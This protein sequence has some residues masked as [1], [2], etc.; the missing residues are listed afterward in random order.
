[1]K[2]PF[3]ILSIPI[4]PYT[5]SEILSC[6]DK[7]IEDN[8]KTFIVTANAEIVMKANEIS[9]FKELICRA[10]I[11]LPD[12]AGVVWAGKYLGYDVPERVA[13][14]DLVQNIFPLATKKNYK[15]Y[16]LGS[17][18]G[19]AATAAKNILKKHP[20]LDIVGTHDGFFDKQEEE[21]IVCEIN[22]KQTDIVLV[23]LGAPKQEQWIVDNMPNLSANIFI[24]I[25]GTFNVMA[26]TAKRAPLWMQKIGME[27]SYRLLC[28]PT[29]VFRMMALPKFVI[30]VLKSKKK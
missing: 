21:K 7:R 1:M 24:G 13:G 28:E 14:Y 17:A 5:M 29:R 27:W 20:T 10:D 8:K 2:E 6:I 26:G 18:P 15:L 30:K 16:F 22:T 12:G 25:G 11:V 19:V 23:A 3:Q 9:F 4:N